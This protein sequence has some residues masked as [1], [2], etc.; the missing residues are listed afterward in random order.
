MCKG[1]VDSWCPAKIVEVGRVQVIQLLS[2]YLVSLLTNL[3]GLYQIGK[4]A[5]HSAYVCSWEFQKEIIIG[6]V[7]LTVVTAPRS[8]RAH[9]LNSTHR[10]KHSFQFFMLA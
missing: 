10:M 5:Y 4:C 6:A 8:V 9:C 3:T 7:S 2:I 1:S